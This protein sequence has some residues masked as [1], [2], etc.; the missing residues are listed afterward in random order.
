MNSSSKP[1]SLIR[2]NQNR[3]LNGPPS[4]ASATANGILVSKEEMFHKNKTFNYPK[5]SSTMRAENFANIR[6][7]VDPR[8]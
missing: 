3:A 4:A 2:N 7:N 5:E 6:E 8:R 1:S